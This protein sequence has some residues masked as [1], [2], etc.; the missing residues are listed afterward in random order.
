MNRFRNNLL[1]PKTFKI[2]IDGFSVKEKAV[3]TNWHA[4]IN[5]VN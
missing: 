2:K 1:I 4:Y 3:N 5:N